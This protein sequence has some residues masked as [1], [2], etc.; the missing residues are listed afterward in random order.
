M[1]P[2]DDHAADADTPS[3]FPYLSAVQAGQG[4][5]L[6]DRAYALVLS[7]HLMASPLLGAVAL[8]SPLGEGPATRALGEGVGIFLVMAVL[9]PPVA[10]LAFYL[11][12]QWTRPPRALPAELVRCVV[13]LVPLLPLAAL[14]GVVI[15]LVVVTGP[16]FLLVSPEAA[17]AGTSLFV[18]YAALVVGRLRPRRPRFSG[19]ERS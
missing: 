17:V 19:F 8:E 2:T 13:L 1:D 15:H 18:F 9:V 4:R 14:L 12:W 7:M 16:P 6:G 3:P 5:T 11:W 10:V